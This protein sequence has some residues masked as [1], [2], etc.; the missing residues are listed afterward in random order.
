VLCPCHSS[1][2]EQSPPDIIKLTRL[3]QKLKREL[4]PI[5][6]IEQ[7]TLFKAALALRHI[8]NSRLFRAE[9]AS[10][11]LNA[12]TMLLGKNLYALITQSLADSRAKSRIPVLVVLWV[13][14]VLDWY[15]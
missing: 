5:V 15:D 14:L 8:R 9:A 6:A 2:R 13:V 7:P 1:A 3:E 4:E 12:H 11:A 10:F